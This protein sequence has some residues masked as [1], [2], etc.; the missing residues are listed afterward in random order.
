MQ[1]SNAQAGPSS[2]P[3][4]YLPLQARPPPRQHLASTQDLLARFHLLPAYDKYVRP[5][6]IPSPPPPADGPEQDDDEGAA[7]GKGEKK[8]KNSYK[9]LIKGIPGKHSMKKD[10][11]LTQA[12]LAP[13]KQR[14]RI[15]PFDVR[16]QQEAF[17]VSL[18]GLKGWNVTALIVE[19][20]QARE[21]RKKRKELKRLAKAQQAQAAAAIQAVAGSS[22]PTVAQPQPLPAHRGASATPQIHPSISSTPKPV[23]TPRPQSSMVPRPGSAVPRPGSAVPRPASTAPRPSSTAPNS[24]MTGIKQE[25][26]PPIMVSTPSSASSESLRGKKRERED[27]TMPING[28]PPTTEVTYMNGAVNGVG[29]GNKINAKAGVGNVRPRPTKKQRMDVQGQARDVSAPVQQP[30]PQ[31]V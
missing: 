3:A 21:D 29:N 2:P 13:E 1:T 14:T 24:S 17:A 15:H 9:A 28:L 6:A 23:A 8:K 7:G 18:E 31:G 20:A 26:A 12:I 5:F 10:D 11:Y 22:S 25:P 19:N 16:T 27:G 30:T 4:L